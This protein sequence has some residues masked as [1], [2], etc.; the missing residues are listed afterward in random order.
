[1]ETNM[2][3]IKA[4][5]LA[6]DAHKKNERHLTVAE[7][8]YWCEQYKLLAEQAISEAEQEPTPEWIYNPITGKRIEP[9]VEQEIQVEQAISEAEQA[10]SITDCMMNLVDRLGSE[11]KEVD[12]KAWK[13][14]LI[15]APKAEQEPIWSI[16]ECAKVIKTLK[17]IQGIAERGEGRPMRDNETLEEFVLG[18]VKRLEQAEQEPVGDALQIASV[19]LQDIACSSQTE[20]IL[21]WQQ[22]A[23]DAQKKISERLTDTAPPQREWVSLTDD[24]I[25]AAYESW[26]KTHGNHAFPIWVGAKAVIEKLKEKNH[27]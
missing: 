27:G 3:N 18:Y 8:R 24:E 4:M 12:P 11:C 2:T 21:W 1:M 19:A 25:K 23:R 14:L 9:H 6:L 15:Y 26:W 7:T 10:E 5:K 16:D 22:R 13:H 17:Y 20:N